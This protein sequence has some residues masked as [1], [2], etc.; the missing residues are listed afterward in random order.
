MIVA[1]TNRRDDR[2][3]VLELRIAAAAA[4]VA[5]V[6]RAV[7]RFLADNDVVK[8]ARDDIVLMVSEL[9][10]NAVNAV[11]ASAR[12][13]EPIDVRVTVDSR[14][15]VIEIEDRGGDV[16]AHAP[17]H[18]PDVSANRGRGLPIVHH[19]AESVEVEQI[20]GT[21]RVRARYR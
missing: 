5:G 17:T 4:E 18:L 21:T 2:H 9:T 7:Q 19:L 14:G 10:T 12:A 1:S 16:F 8:A 11:N 20:E 3:E 13:G 15:T 6:R